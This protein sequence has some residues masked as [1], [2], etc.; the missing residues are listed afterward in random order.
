MN[1]E[2]EAK[3][4][5]VNHD[6]IRAILTGLGAICEK[7]MRTM[8]R[9]TFDNPAMKAKGGW[10]RVRDEGDKVTTA[11]KQID[12]LSLDGMKEIELEVSDFDNMVDIYRALELEGGSYQESKRETCK[13]GDVEIVLDEWP[14]LQPLIEVEGPSELRV[15]EVAE[16][17]GFDM[18]SAMHGDITVVYKIQYPFL[19][20]SFCTG[21]LPFVRFN[22][23]IPEQLKE[24]V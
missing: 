23:P 21:D 8:R 14:W 19:G 5:G 11:Y 9:Y 15:A 13:L 4:Y 16:Q 17:L 20:D 2:I 10:I 18:N 7:P 3:F 1:T 6:D 22:D 12:K 24:P